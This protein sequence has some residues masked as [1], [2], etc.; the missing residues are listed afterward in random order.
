MYVAMRMLY[1]AYMLLSSWMNAILCVNCIIIDS[2]PTKMPYMH[3]TYKG[4]T[5]NFILYYIAQL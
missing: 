3:Y 4:Q 5:H 1:I 2:T